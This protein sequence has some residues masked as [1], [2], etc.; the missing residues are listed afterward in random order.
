MQLYARVTHVH[1]KHLTPQKAKLSSTIAWYLAIT[2]LGINV[3]TPSHAYVGSFIDHVNRQ[4]ERLFT[5]CSKI[6]SLCRQH[7]RVH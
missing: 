2:P 1:V 4:Q 7:D 5:N 6:I 3:H